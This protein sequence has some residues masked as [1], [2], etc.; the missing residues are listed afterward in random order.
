MPL[1][2]APQAA[3]LPTA[4][5]LTVA[6]FKDAPTDVDLA[7]LVSGGDQQQQDN[8][9]ATLIAQASAWMDGYVHYPLAA[10]LDTETRRNV[11][12]TRDGYVRVPVRGVPILEV[13]SF[14][15]GIVPSQMAAITSAPDGWVE[16]NVIWMPVIVTT[17]PPRT[18][19]FGPGDRLFCTWSY[20]NGYANTLMASTAAPGASSI[21]VA[22]AL[23]IYA[24]TNL[25]IY[26]S[27]RTETVVVASGY[28]STT[29]PGPT[30]IPLAGALQFA[31]QTVGISVSALPPNV[32]KAAVL[33]TTAFIKTRG[34]AGLV[35]DT[36]ASGHPKEATG[37]QGGIEDL[38]MAEQ[39]LQRYVLPTYF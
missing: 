38:A 28:V 3:G 35:M 10:T 17:I 5:Y 18:S 1:L 7:S 24:G 25:T 31:H 2:L 26:D 12:I 13:D 15:V 30:V 37:E 4:S 34:S 32:K 27:G 36:I 14:S 39:L 20:V 21:S 6:E 33:A 23:G 19:I 8:Q 16:D 11:R 22:S 29:G 9:L